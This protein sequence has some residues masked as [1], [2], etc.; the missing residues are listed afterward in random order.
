MEATLAS[1]RTVLQPGAPFLFDVWN[2]LAVLRLSPEQ[3]VKEVSD[4]DSR[5]LRVVRPELD[6]ALHLCMTTTGLS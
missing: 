3:R 1:I 6:A 2:G 4:G 5:L